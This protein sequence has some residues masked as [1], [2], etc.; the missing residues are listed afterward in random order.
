MPRISIEPVFAA[1]GACVCSSARDELRLMN[2]DYGGPEMKLHLLMVFLLLFVLLSTALLVGQ[3]FRGT[4][5]GSVTDPSGAYVSGATVKVRNVATGIERTTVTSGDGSYRVPELPIGTYS[6]TVTQT[7]FQTAVTNDVVVDVATERRVDAQLKTGQVNQMVEVSGGDLPQIETQSNDLGGVI[8]AQVAD[9]MPVNGRDYTKLIY[10][11]PGVAGSPDQI[12]DSPGSFGE[13]SMNGARGRS[14]N[15][16][17]D[18]TDMNDGYRNDP[19]I[20]QAGVFGTPATILPID[21]VAEVNVLSNFQPEYGRNAGAVVNIVTKSGANK[22]HGTAGEYMRNDALDARN[23]FNPSSQPKALFHNNQFGASVGGPIIKDKTFFYVD[24]EGQKEP[25]GVVTVSDVPTGTAADG[26]LQPSD[27]SNPAIAAL[28]ARHPWPAPNLTK[29][30][31]LETTG[32]A[33][34]ISPSYNDLTSMIVKIDQNFNASNILTGRYFFGDSV[35]SF[36]LALAAEGGQLPG[37]NTFTPTRVQ[38]TSLSYVHTFGTSKV[39]ELRY[40]WNRFAEGFFPFDQSFH[41]SSIGLCAATS[42]PTSGLPDSCNGTAPYDAGL[43][44]IIISGSTGLSSPNPATTSAAQLGAS[45]GVPRDRI[46]SNDQLID[47][48]SWKLNKH[49]LKFGFDFFRTTVTQAEFDHNFR[50]KLYFDGTTTGNAIQ[51]FLAGD[52]DSGYQYFGDATRHTFENSFG[53][54]AQDSY[55]VNPRLTL[56]YGFRWDYYGVIGEKNNLFSNV[57]NFDLSGGT[58]TLTQ[59]GQPG[60]SS[61]YNP[62]KKDF[63]PRVSIA[64]DVTG[65]GKTVVRIGYGLFYDAASQ[66]MVMG[67]LP[68]SPAFDPGPAFNNATTIPSAYQI[69]ST[70]ATVGPI[71]PGGTVTPL[72]VP[73]NTCNYECDTFAFDRNIKTP[74]MENYNLNFQ[75]QLTS[76]TVIQVGYVGSEGHR[77]WRF[78][79]LS[80]P[81]VAQITASDC[82]NGI[83]TCATTGAITGEYGVP[84]NYIPNNPYGSF[85]LLQENSTGKSNYNALQLSFRVNSWHGITSVL[86]YVYSKSLD[87]SSDGEDFEPNAAQPN[88]SNNPQKEYGLSNFNIPQRLTW[89]FS[90]EF[91]NRSGDWKRLKNGWGIDSVLSLQDGQPFQL[92]YNFEDDYSGGGSGFDRPDVVG[93]IKYDAH[94]PSQYLDLSSFAIPCDTTGTVTGSRGDC[95]PGTRHYGNEGRDSL[96]GP[97]FKEWN[98]AVFKNTAITERVKAQFR[99]D[100]F[101]LPNHPNFANPFLPSY[102]ADAGYASFQNA[103]INGVNREV[104]GTGTCAGCS[105]FYPIS[106]TGDVGIGN[107]FIGGGGPRGIQLA[108]KFTF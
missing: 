42:G 3:T 13:F 101:N 89:N 38:L 28:L 103:S 72:F 21:A 67:H 94:N 46:D 62:D 73:T 105:N 34:V 54:Y 96:H 48:F 35:Q 70:V 60:L 58:F 66:D 79:D 78:F 98:F 104:G 71:N 83:A 36:P 6:V 76:K 95:I 57:T 49:D 26:S 47:N 107:P 12:S 51:D 41:P 14:N 10:L 45:A 65:K 77:L 97:S 99:V 59:V 40:G 90:Y 88:D 106:A 55:R 39:N 25:V 50:G 4:I 74:Y 100:F 92:N 11:N 9:D 31:P 37:F 63:A 68:Y 16:L 102:I 24:Y 43:P 86:N 20:N 17:L 30:I 29:G 23:Y 2:S 52:V 5:L 91:P 44:V 15:Y 64:W 32:T 8:T 22:I 61:L 81:S 75:Q 87:N 85:Y 93:P 108:V 19:A 53:F 84:R 7:G 33:S 82:P 80:Q 69:L 56:N 1:R 18:G 27:A